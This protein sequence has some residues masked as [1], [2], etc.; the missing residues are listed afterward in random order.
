MTSSSIAV[1]IVNHN[2]RDALRDCLE[3]VVAQTP[4]QTIV[5][6]SASS[7]GS[8]EMVR[9][10]FPVVELRV[11]RNRGY[12][13]AAN[14]ALARARS[15]YVL[16]LNADTRVT[17]GALTALVEYL[18][19]HPS[20]AFVGPRVVDAHGTGQKTAHRFPTPS[21]VFFRESGL[22]KLRIARRPASDAAPHRV[23]WV[24]GAAL[25]IRRRAF[26]SVGGFDE[27]YFMYNEETDLCLRA[28]R[29]GWEVHFA[30]VATVVH[31]GGASTAQQ[32]RAM[33]A[34]YMRSTLLLYKHHL[35]PAKL[36]QVRLVLRVALGA[37]I[38]RDRGQLALARRVER[39][40]RLDESLEAWRAA[41]V[42]LNERGAPPGPPGAL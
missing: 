17:P 27:S 31:V 21:Q 39:R 34:Q 11:S 1:A 5:V 15:D 12:G 9:Q 40:R 14:V 37:R 25:A 22:H 36:R 8:P 23:D 38:A 35:P 24:L 16:L 7:D 6:D 29:A 20:A 13:A 30:P 3:T 32:R 18:D 42:A 2:T 10:E 28:R 19:Q 4:A 33:L 41:W 26:E